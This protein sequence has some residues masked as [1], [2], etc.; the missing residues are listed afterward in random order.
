MADEIK[1]DSDKLKAGADKLKMVADTETVHHDTNAKKNRR[2]P[3]KMQEMNLT[4]MLDVCFQLLIFFILTTSFTV[5]EG[6]LPAALPFGQGPAQPDEPPESPIRVSIDSAGGEDFSIQVSGH[7]QKIAS[8]DALYSVLEDRKRDYGAE[9]KTPVE[10]NPGRAV[11]WQH[12]MNAFN[13]ARRAKFKM[14]SFAA[15]N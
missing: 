3:V 6:L 13:Q 12:V 1:P 7:A 4:A 5:T 9:S 11:E 15:V 2:K 10:I 14:V 8:W